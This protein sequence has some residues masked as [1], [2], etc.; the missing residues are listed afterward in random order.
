MVASLIAYEGDSGRS[1]LAGTVHQLIAIQQLDWMISATV[2]TGLMVLVGITSWRRLRRRM[3][4]ETWYFL[5]LLGYLAILLAV[6]HAL[7]LGSDIAGDTWAIAWWVGL[8]AVVVWLLVQRRVISLVR[9][10]VRPGLHV[11]GVRDDGGDLRT[12]TV[13]GPGL[14]SLSGRPGQWYRLRFGGRGWWWQTHPYSASAAPSTGGLE[15]TIAVAGDSSR[16]LAHARLGTRVW[17]EGPYGVFTRAA[18]K[19]RPLLL[20]GGGSGLAPLR[21]ILQ[22]ASATDRPVL[23]LRARSADDIPY[24]GEMEALAARSGGHA[25]HAIGRTAATSGDMFDPDRLRHAIPDLTDRDAF[26]CGPPGLILAARRG[27]IRAGLDPRHIHSERY[28]Y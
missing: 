21:A 24:H 18:A 1:L 5:H 8:Y 15:F 11:S 4:Y 2:A 6:G 10:L 23:L 26:L 14:R 17:L 20:I 9:S 7:V 27:L 28:D 22:D 13:S 25:F 3:S 12:I 16:A 19:G